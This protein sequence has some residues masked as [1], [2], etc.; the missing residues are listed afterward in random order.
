MK[1]GASLAKGLPPGKLSLRANGR[2]SSLQ[3]ENMEEITNRCAKLKL[4]LREDVEV[5]IQAPLTKEGPVLIGK[6]CTKRK[7]NLDRVWREY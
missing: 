3:Q 4:S 7:I 2:N 1:K 6:F 5:A